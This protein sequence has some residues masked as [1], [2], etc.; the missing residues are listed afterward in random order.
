M[1]TSKYSSVITR[2]LE[3][4]NPA[5]RYKTRVHVLSEDS[6]GV[7]LVKLQ[8]EI[9]KSELVQNLLSEQSDDGTIPKNPYSKWSGGHWV[10]SIL[11]E[12]DYPKNDKT[13]IP[14]REQIY[15]WIFSKHHQEKSTKL[16]NGLYRRCASQEGNIIYSLIKLGLDDSRTET[17]VERL[18]AYQWPDGGWNCDKRETACN[19]SYN[20]SLLPVRALIYFYNKYGNEDIKSS[21]DKCVELFL[22]RELF[23]SQKTNQPI[24][25]NFVKLNFPY[26]WPYNIL[27]ALKVFSEYKQLNDIRVNDALDL[28]ESKFIPNEGFPAEIKYYQLTKPTV[29]RYSKVNWGG[30]SKRRMNEFVTVEV[31]QV[32]NRYGRL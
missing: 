30:V 9:K 2:L 1:R 28:I 8:Q 21:I 13:L 15:S 32:L 10:L 11:A 22:K 19:S 5:V 6:D 17:L 23:K 24:K 26:Y 27:L 4:D 20:E 3:S 25:G 29:A 16:I 7:S 12:L 31:L 14:I 18:I